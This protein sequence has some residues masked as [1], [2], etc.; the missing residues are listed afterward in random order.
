MAQR[1]QASSKGDVTPLFQR[2]LGVGMQAW[3]EESGR[4]PIVFTGEREVKFREISC[5]FGG[6]GDYAG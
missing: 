4:G 1:S 5:L 2:I 3:C 6:A